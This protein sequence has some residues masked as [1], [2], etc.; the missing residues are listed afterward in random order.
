MTQPR[1]ACAHVQVRCLNEAVVGSCQGVFKPWHQRLDL[2]GA[3]LRSS[4]DDP[5][6]LLH[7]PFTGAVKL[8]AI[9]VVGGPD[10]A[11]PAA[12]RVFINRDD[13]DFATAAELPAVQKW[14]LAETRDGRIEYPTQ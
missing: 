14:D 12:L 8:R 3:A 13:L 1:P 10:G 6:L 2:G 11:A 4:D 9:S 7:V 5:E